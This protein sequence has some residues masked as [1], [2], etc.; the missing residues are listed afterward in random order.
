MVLYSLVHVQYIDHGIPWP[1]ATI[2]YIRIRTACGAQWD[3]H[4]NG[5]ICYSL[6]H[7]TVALLSVGNVV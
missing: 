1:H 2:L 3:T 4:V 7:D 6:S 5:C